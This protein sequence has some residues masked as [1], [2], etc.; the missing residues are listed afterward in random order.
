MISQEQN[1][2]IWNFW[3]KFYAQLEDWIGH[4]KLDILYASNLSNQEISIQVDR[5]KNAAIK[6]YISSTHTWIRDTTRQYKGNFYNYPLECKVCG[7]AASDSEEEYIYNVKVVNIPSRD[8]HGHR[9]Y[10]T[11]QEVLLAKKKAR[12]LHK[13]PKCMQCH[14]YD[15]IENQLD[16]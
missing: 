13:G 2:K 1:K 5:L 11:C 14:T 3:G 6:E 8:M 16:K 7:Q 12:Q 10:R 9:I 15:C 4:K